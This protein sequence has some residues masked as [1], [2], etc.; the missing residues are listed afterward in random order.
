MAT[1]SE[2]SRILELERD[3]GLRDKEVAALRKS[4]EA[5]SGQDGVAALQEEL[6]SLHTQLAAQGHSH[7]AE[8]SSLRQTLAAREEELSESLSQLQSS[9]G[10]LSKDN[11]QLSGQLAKSKEEN[12]N[13]VEEWRAKLAS[14]EASHQQALEELRASREEVRNALEQTHKVE[15]AEKHA[16][17][18]MGWTGEAK[19]HKTQ[20]LKVSEE[21]ERL[22]ETLRT[23]LEKAEEQ[24]LLEMEE[25]LGK[26][27]S[28]ELRVKE[29]EDTGVKIGQ[30][31]REKTQDA[32]EQETALET[33]R[34]QHRDMQRLL[35]Q[36]EEARSHARPQEEKVGPYYTPYACRTCVT[37]NL[38][39][40]IM[41]SESAV[42]NDFGTK[43]FF[44]VRTRLDA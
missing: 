36:V 26:L 34:S 24:H 15:L 32:L 13:I 16:S 22:V 20:L 7:Q 29:L 23:S 43:W 8:L 28:A 12:S 9:A 33:L 30:Q 3:L 1:V 21:N 38:K 11:E 44:G 18:A 4:L 17:E 2:K 10:R 19:E 35:T 40:V 27:H 5:V 41:K 31:L 25:V 6:C 14:V 42:T 37:R 39:R